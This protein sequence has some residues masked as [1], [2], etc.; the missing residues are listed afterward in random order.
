MT[1]HPNSINPRAQAPA[2]RRLIA[3]NHRRGYDVTI[4]TERG[5]ERYDARRLVPSPA[6][7]VEQDLGRTDDRSTADALQIEKRL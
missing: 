1:V 3:R 2:R 7:G 6:V 5:V 4:D